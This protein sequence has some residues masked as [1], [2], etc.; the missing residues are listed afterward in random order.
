MSGRRPQRPGWSTD[1]PPP[2]LGS[3]E[4]TEVTSPLREG[5]RAT[6]LIPLVSSHLGEA[7]EQR[8]DRGQGAGK[9]G[10]PES[11]G[12]CERPS[13]LGAGQTWVPGS[14]GHGFLSP[15]LQPRLQLE[16]SRGP[17]NGCGV[18]AEIHAGPGGTAYPALA[19]PPPPRS[20]PGPAPGPAPSTAA[21]PPRAGTGRR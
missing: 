6:D 18:T 11:S 9:R 5:L 19:P 17:A 2:G 13:E 10:W 20:A 14:E 21:A 4:P 16:A 7:A 12:V 15:A 1:V 3:H 8:E